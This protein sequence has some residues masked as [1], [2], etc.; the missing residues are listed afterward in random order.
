MSNIQAELKI[1]GIGEIVEID[2]CYLC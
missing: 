1:G 2:E